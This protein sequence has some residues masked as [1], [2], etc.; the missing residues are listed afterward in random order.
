M[1]PDFE[2]AVRLRKRGDRGH[3]ASGVEMEAW[4]YSVPDRETWER[5]R[6]RR[7][8][9]L[10]SDLRRVASRLERAFS[11]AQEMSRLKPGLEYFLAKESAHIPRLVSHP[12]FHLWLFCAKRLLENKARDVRESWIVLDQ[13]QGFAASL[14]CLEGD[15]LEMAALCDGN[16]HFHFHGLRTY[17]DLGARAAEKETVL[18]FSPDGLEVALAGGC[19]W[20]VKRNLLLDGRP[21]APSPGGGSAGIIQDGLTIRRCPSVTDA[22]EVNDCDPLI[23][24]PQRVCEDRARHEVTAFSPEEMSRFTDVLR[25]AMAKI[26]EADPGLKRELSDSIRVVVPLAREDPKTHVSSSYSHLRGAVFLCHDDNPYLQAETLIH[27]FCHNKLYT[28]LELDPLFKE[29]GGEPIYYSPWRPDPRPLIG[30]LLGAHAFLNVARFYALSASRG[31][32]TPQVREGLQTEAAMRCSQVDLALDVLAG[33][34]T[35]TDL[36]RSLL[37]GM[38]RKLAEIAKLLPPPP[39]GIWG[40]ARE[41]VDEHLRRYRGSPKGHHILAAK[42][43]ATPKGA[44]S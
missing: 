10:V 13:F 17:L 23:L 43:C 40:A 22:M 26:E 12:A 38:R 32:H 35:L 20:R 15:S 4:I 11:G 18:G 34:A 39:G 44:A 24:L 7:T 8:T 29:G 37:D 42:P 6:A 36:G 1:S 3:P 14:A 21:A 30:I 19:R 2:S 27:E 16:G 41:P 28:L 5:A 25:R 33:N 31:G 9:A